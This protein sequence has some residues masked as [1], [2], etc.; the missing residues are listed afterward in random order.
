MIVSR[1][2]S[3]ESACEFLHDRYEEAAKTHSWQTNDK[4]AVPWADVPDA[5]KATMRDAVAALLKELGIH[6]AQ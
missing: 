5:N 3:L 4:S 6:Y 2:V 1:A